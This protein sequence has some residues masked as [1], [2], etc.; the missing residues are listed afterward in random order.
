MKRERTFAGLGLVALGFVALSSSACADEAAAPNGGAPPVSDEAV[1]LQG[2]GARNRPCREWSD[3]CSTCLRDE[4]DA[5]H[6][7]TPGIA[8]Q[9]AAIVCRQTTAQ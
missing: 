4:K 7:S 2:F 5:P 9:A 1:S 8:C 3:G 6:C